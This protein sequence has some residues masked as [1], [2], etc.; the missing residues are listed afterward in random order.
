MHVRMCVRRTLPSKSPWCRQ[1]DLVI[2]S[3]HY[4]YCKVSTTKMALGTQQ[5]GHPDGEGKGSL[6][7]A[8]G[9]GD[10]SWE[11]KGN[12]R[13]VAGPAAEEMAP[14]DFIPQMA[15]FNTLCSN[16]REINYT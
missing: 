6:L 3:K 10:Q 11:G 9:G 1:G 15:L 2:S 16:I 12:K 14:A 8:G 7:G 4:T 13:V 5:K